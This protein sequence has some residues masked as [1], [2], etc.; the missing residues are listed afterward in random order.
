MR[1]AVEMGIYLPIQ[2]YERSL[3]SALSGERQFLQLRC[4]EARTDLFVEFGGLPVVA[5]SPSRKAA[6]AFGRTCPSSTS[7]A[8]SLAH[9]LR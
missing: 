3:P 7:S 9:D 1:P 2:E 8:Y 5:M 6:S 4:T